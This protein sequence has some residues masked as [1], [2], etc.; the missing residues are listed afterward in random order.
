MPADG[1]AQDTE[2]VSQTTDSA[3]RAERL[4]DKWDD[5]RCRGFSEPELLRYR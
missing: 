5:E 1:D 4:P 2:P 3:T